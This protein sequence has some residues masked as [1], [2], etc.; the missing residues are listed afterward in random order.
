MK[1]RITALIV[2]AALAASVLAGCAGSGSGATQTASTAEPASAAQEDSGEQDAGWPE[3]PINLIVS[4]GAGGDGDTMIRLI[5][6]AL[7]KE[8]GTQIAITNVAGGNGSIAMDQ[9][10]NSTEPD[11][12]TFLVNNTAA[13]A[14]NPATGLVDY[15]W[16][17]AC[18]PV[19]VYAKHSGEILWVRK[20]SPYQTLEDAVAASQENPD[21]I[22]LGI[23]MGGSVYAASIMLQQA[24]G[25]FALVDAGDGSDR[26]VSLLGGQVDIA[27]AGYGI[28]KEYIESG[29]LRPLC[30][31]MGSRSAALPDVPAAN[32]SGYDV[33]LNNLFLIVAPKGTDDAVKQKFADAII[34]VVMND[35]EVGK[36]ILDYS[37][38]NPYAIGMEETAAELDK[39]TASFMAISDILQNN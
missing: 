16:D 26:I 13:L 9:L 4:M 18:E 23:S 38:Q 5:A 3:K 2:T 28:G 29:D 12:Y 7:E 25:K 24:G 34:K 31:L 15:T 20:D 37:G 6:P 33:E 11:G 30:T 22:T 32:E 21:K 36:A 39:Q 8:L 10:M 19:A 35:E 14:A 17:E 27:D 1:K